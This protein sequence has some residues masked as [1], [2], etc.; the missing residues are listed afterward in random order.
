MRTLSKGKLENVKREMVRNSVNVMS[1][2]EVR[3]IG[4]GVIESEEV[5]MYYS[6]GEEKQRGVA[7]VLDKEV[8]RK[9]SI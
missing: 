8:A 6:R 1:L 9:V 2:S 7:V 5:K 3:W 4:S